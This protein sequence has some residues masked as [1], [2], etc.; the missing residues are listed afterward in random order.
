MLHRPKSRLAVA[1][2][3]GTVC[4]L[5]AAGAAMAAPTSPWSKHNPAVPNAYTNTTPALSE[6]QVNG[7]LGTFLAWKGQADNKVQYKYRLDG[8]WHGTRVIPGAYTNTSPSAALFAT[9][10][11]QQAVLVA[12]KALG[13]G[14]LA[15]IKYSDGVVHNNGSISWTTPRVL[16]G[17]LLSETF[18]SPALLFPAN[19]NNPRVIL[20]YR[21][22]YN[23][24]RVA[25]GTEKGRSFSWGTK[26]VKSAIIG[27]SALTDAQPAL[28]E[29]LGAG[30]NG[31][32]Y[33]FWKDQGTIAE[34][35]SYA[36]TPDLE[37]SGLD[38]N[39]S[40]HWTLLGAVPDSAGVKG[41]AQTTGSPAVASA[42]LQGDGPL[43]LAYK[44][45]GGFN[46]RYQTFTAGAVTPWS[47]DGFVGPNNN[48]TALGP[49]LVHGTL[50]N[51]SRTDARIFLHQY[52]S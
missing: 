21:G 28:T 25:I 17:G 16:P 38:G 30:G 35:I 4:A 6:I 22:P 8:R 43:L 29:I 7:Q 5:I 31:T 13:H 24:V 39:A 3:G 42:D 46:I 23:H 20:A 36:S 19:A 37:G 48:T 10:L 49:A 51:V 27:G 34:P 44:G 11:S 47:K 9:K 41:L 45:P 14:G 26:K 52:H 50:A 2:A 33:V 15:D 18:G 40:L 1:A 12:W 32:V